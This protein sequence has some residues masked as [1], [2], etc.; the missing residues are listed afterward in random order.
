M[1]LVRRHG[2][3]DRPRDQVLPWI[4]RVATNHCLNLKRDTRRRGEDAALPDLDLAD[5]SALRALPR[6][7]PGQAGAG[8][9]RR[10]RPRRWRWACWSTAWST[11]SWPRC[12]ASR[13]APWRAG[14][15]A[16]STAPAA[17]WEGPDHGGPLP[18]RPGAGAPPAGARDLAAPAAP[19]RLRLLP[20]PARG[21]E[22]PGRGLPPVRLPG[23]GGGR[24]G[25][26][27]GASAPAAALAG[28]GTGPRRGRGDGAL[29]GPPGEP[30][31]WRRRH[32][33]LAITV[34][35]DEG[36]APG[37]SAAARRWPPPRRSASGSRP[38]RPAGSGSS[39]STPPGS[40]RA[41]TR[42]RAPAGPP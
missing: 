8:Q 18:L 6:P 41:S 32:G 23:H 2:P 26:R 35:V 19:G 3:P 12:S 4:Y 5:P 31:R 30:T 27:S 24:G 22:P 38:P 39:R 17:S 11:R 9:L 36:R 29:P 40:S 37:P 13:A 21:D 1:K 15:S 10:G 33:G 16:S 7:D 34:L 14:W 20:G 28:A 42:A 25:G